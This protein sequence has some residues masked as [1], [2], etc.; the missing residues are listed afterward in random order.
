MPSNFQ[1]ARE[2]TTLTIP[3]NQT[4]S[5]T[6]ELNGTHLVAVLFPNAFTSSKLKIQGSLD[7]TNF[8]DVYGSESGTTKEI[9][10]TVNTITVV[11]NNYD[12]PF[13]FIR[14]VS[15]SAETAE[16]ILKIVCNP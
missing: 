3:N 12:N 11:E 15:N 6:Y 5:S 8:Y 1:S 4:T 13:N 2:F 14:L 16:R 7:G 9:K 10:V